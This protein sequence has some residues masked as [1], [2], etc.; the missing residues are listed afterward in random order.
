MFSSFRLSHWVDSLVD[1]SGEELG[2]V[3]TLVEAS[4]KDDRK[5]SQQFF[6]PRRVP[7]FCAHCSP[8]GLR[9]G[10]AGRAWARGSVVR[11]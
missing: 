8:L 7:P 1:G 3:Q 5:H 6:C 9:D 4:L 11:L 10:A 2:G